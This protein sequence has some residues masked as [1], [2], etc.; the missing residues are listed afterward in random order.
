MVRGAAT[1]G[2]VYLWTAYAQLAPCDVVLG[3]R[4]CLRL[5]CYGASMGMVVD[6]LCPITYF[7]HRS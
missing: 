1:A 4:R 6:A 2:G 3:R 5:D 7:S